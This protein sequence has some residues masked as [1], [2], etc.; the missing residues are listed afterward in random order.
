MVRIFS[1][2]RPGAGA[3]KV[4]SRFH[5]HAS[6]LSGPLFVGLPAIRIGWRRETNS[7]PVRLHV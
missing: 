7:G 2:T 4:S 1:A 6:D 5:A 3:A